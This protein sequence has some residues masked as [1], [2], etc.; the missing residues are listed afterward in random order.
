ML[1]AELARPRRD[2]FGS[3]HADEELLRAIREIV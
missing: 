2:D 1:R 3:I